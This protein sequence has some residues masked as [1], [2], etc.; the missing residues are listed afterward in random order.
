MLKA[1]LV[2]DEQP[3][4]D[5]LLFILKSFPEISVALSTTDPGA[6]LDALPLTQPDVVFLDINIPLINGFELAEKINEICPKCLLVFITAYDQYAL[7]AFGANAVGYLLKP[8][9]TSKMRKTVERLLSLSNMEGPS[10]HS[11]S[12]A[13]LSP[14]KAESKQEMNDNVIKIPVYN[15][16]NIQMIDPKDALFFTVIAHDVFLVTAK[17]KYRVRN[18]LNYW[19]EKLKDR[20][21]FRCHRGYLIN[22]DKLNS[23]SPMFNS[24]YM[25]KMQG[26][27]EEVVVSRNYSAKFRELLNL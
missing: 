19:E 4:L 3:T 23:V 24:T 1:M 7:E 11:E 21:Y 10:R 15:S 20:H 9:T 22:L 26:S 18:S 8:V 5:N 12:S 25:I 17:G 13:I 14:E 27:S 16:N 2:D 6:I